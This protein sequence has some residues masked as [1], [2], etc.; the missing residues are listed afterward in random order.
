MHHRYFIPLFAISMPLLGQQ[1]APTTSAST[2]PTELEEVV[3][4]GKAEDLIGIA[5]AASAGRASAQDIASR[6]LLR[7]SEILETIPGLITTQHAGGG[8]ATQYFLRGFNLD[9][10]TD[11]ATHLDSMPLNLK[12]HAHG[13]GYTDLNFIIP[14]MIDQIDYVK[15]T[16]TAAD[17]DLSTAGSAN[18]R[19]AHSL[20]R[21]FVTA[22]VGEFGWYRGVI[23]G[24][25]DLSGSASA[26]APAAASSKNPGK[27]PVQP[28]LPS[29]ETNALTYALEY[30]QYD[31]PWDLSEDFQRW[32][33]MLRWFKGDDD[34]HFAATLMGGHTEWTSSDQVALRA[35]NRG[36]ISRFGN[37]DPTNGGE[38]QRYSLNLEWA[39]REGDVVT[40]ANLFGIYYDLNLFSN[41][42]YFLDYPDQ[43][44]QFEQSEQR[45]ILG[46]NLSRTWENQQLFGKE[47]QWTVGVQT[48]HDLIDGIG[49][50]RTTARERFANIRQDDVYQANISLYGENKVKWNDWF[51]TVVGLRGDLFYFD[52]QSN[53]PANSGDELAGIISPK[54]SAIFGPWH[55]TELYLNFGT[56]FHSNDSRGTT[57]VIDPNSGDRIPTV[58]PL[59]R[60]YGAEFGVRTQAISSL[61]STLTFFWLRSDSELV[62]VGDAGLNEAGSGSQRYGIEW[63]NYWRPTDWF[64]M[65]AEIALTHARFLD[66]GNDDYIPNSV[67]MMFSG[68][69]NLGAQAQS[70][71]FFANFRFRAFG[72]RPLIEDNSR[73]SKDSFQ[74]NASVGYRHN[75]WEAAVDCLNLFDRDDNDIEYFYESRLAGESSSREDH[76]IH[77]M[78]PRNFR[79][80]VTYR[81]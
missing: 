49:L 5:P 70:N 47:A 30:N 10:G 35:I 57:T 66:A 23:G 81:F 18:F 25:I 46:G 59:V 15:G 68:G 60:T 19:L 33:G 76:H 73:K 39:S 51:R 31:G 44:D 61:T 58:D 37:L 64:S 52:N 78:E 4:T 77:P 71:G 26:S 22:E 54:L 67:P 17:G 21:D 75:N 3:I 34:N 56:G 20:A 50:W 42:T 43:G 63:A 28:V 12:T 65:D 69:I 32:N 1:A 41:F 13:Q 24:S 53:N 16:Y 7:R 80:R 2:T 9:H 72:R 79:F 45:W 36:I 38:S 14:E 8:K 74:V 6:P 55:D 29:T 48:R 40:K 11:F 27:N 62:Y